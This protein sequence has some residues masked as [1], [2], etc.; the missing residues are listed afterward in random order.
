MRIPAGTVATSDTAPMMPT[1]AAAKE[2]LEPRFS[3]PRTK[4][5]RIAPKPTAKRSDGARTGHRMGLSTRQ[6]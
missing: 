2:E 1:M 6:V 4:T 3:A 5:G